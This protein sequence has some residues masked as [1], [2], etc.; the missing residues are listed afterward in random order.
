[1]T[2]PRAGSAL[3]VVLLLALPTVP[4]AAQTA[5]S[6]AV[7]TACVDKRGKVRVKNRC[8]RGERR[9]RLVAL[10]A[11][12]GPQGPKGDK[13]DPGPAGPTGPT[14]A[15]G[16]TGATGESGT[17]GGTT[18]SAGGGL[19]LAGTVFSLEVPLS[20]TSDPA[21]AVVDVTNTRPDA[22]TTGVRGAAG[23]DE[24]GAPASGVTGVLGVVSTTI[25]GGFSAGVRGVNEG[26]GSSGIGVA[27]VQ[28]GSGWGVFGTTTGS[29]FGVFGRTA[30]PGGTGVAAAYVGS[31]AGDALQVSNGRFRV[32]GDNRPAF[33]HTVA[34]RC[35]SSNEYS[36]LDNP[37]ING[38]PNAM[39]FV[40]QTQTT[41]TTNFLPALSVA[42]ST[43][44]PPPACPANR[45]LL[46]NESAAL[47][48]GT[49]A[50]VLAISP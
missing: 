6:S 19:D 28:K 8:R 38:D 20:L 17:G 47:P 27:G 31:G 21:G 30:S 46:Y 41:A 33:R 3:V 36:P 2:L 26:T 48:T 37:L 40:T 18:Y 43:S 34:T 25:P 35:G 5:G 24:P 14:G 29:G 44:I 32:A 39:L 22:V 15:T 45:W 23:S 50:N 4:A 42:Y 9:I 13:G 12:R 16:A 11:E 7:V 49:Q 1:M 10:P